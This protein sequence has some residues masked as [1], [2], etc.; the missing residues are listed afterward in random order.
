MNN[1]NLYI[2]IS[3][4]ENGK[5]YAYAHKQPYCY[6]LLNL[7]EIKGVEILQPCESWK[8]AKETAERWN[9]VY[10]ANDNYLFDCPRF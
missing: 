4:Q 8:K 1:K 10:K 9:A 5:R 7:S 6:N 3:I 2:V